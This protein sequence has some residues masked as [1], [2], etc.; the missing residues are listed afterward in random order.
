MVKAKQLISKQGSL[1]FWGRWFGRPFDNAHTIAHV[2]QDKD[3]HFFVLRFDEDEVC[4]LRNPKGM[5][6]DA[7]S[8]SIT[9]ADYIRWTWFSYGQPRTEEH[10]NILEYWRLENGT[11][12]EKNNGTET[13]LPLSDHPAFEFLFTKVSLE[14]LKRK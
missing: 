8:F 4:T 6:V 11:I 7:S 1:L 12:V 10:M 14:D 9:F 3:R 5:T 2:E 13:Q